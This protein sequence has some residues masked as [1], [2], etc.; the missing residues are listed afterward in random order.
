[1]VNR[2]KTIAVSEKEIEALLAAGENYLE[3]LRSAP[4]SRYRS[5]EH[6]YGAFAAHRT[7]RNE[8]T[9]NLL[10]LHLTGYLASWGM[11]RG[12]TFLLKEKDYLVHRPIVELLLDPA[13]K[14]LWHPT[15]KTLAQ[16]ENA[17]RVEQLGEE[18]SKIY[19]RLVGRDSE[20]T[21]TLR[22]KILLGTL[23]CSPAYDDNFKKAARALHCG[24]G[25]FNA[26]SLIA[27]A[28]FYNTYFDVFEPF[29]AACS[30]DGMEY[31]PMKIL[32]MCFFAAGEDK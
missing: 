4:D 15:A 10:T 2:E 31:P 14:N 20:V 25:S 27:W 19:C 16:R 5:W 23:G 29:R 32:D 22:T 18:I 7:M 8:E 28:N 17:C 21:D 26:T 24:V 12:S 3:K 1:M 30:H 13:W 9:L 6:C 11:Y